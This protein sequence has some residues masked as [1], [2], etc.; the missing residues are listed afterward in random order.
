MWCVTVGKVDWNHLAGRELYNH[1]RDYQ[2]NWNVVDDAAS[3]AVVA[4]LSQ[5]LHAGWRAALV[6]P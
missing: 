6:V 4:E 2:E 1:S 5:Q 3:A